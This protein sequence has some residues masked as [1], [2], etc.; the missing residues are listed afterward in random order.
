PALADRG[1]VAAL[2]AH[3]LSAIPAASI[4]SDGVAFDTRFTPE[5]ENAVY[6]CC[7]EALQNCAKYAPGAAIHVALRTPEPDW[8][9]FSVRDEGPVFDTAV[10][11]IGSGHQHMADRLSALDVTLKVTPSPG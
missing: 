4:D 9:T 2:E 5:V 6:F 10:V 1:I 7:L 11:L 8:L 3:L